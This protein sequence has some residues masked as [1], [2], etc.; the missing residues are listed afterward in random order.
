[1]GFGLGKTVSSTSD[2]GSVGP[3]CQGKEMG[4]DLLEMGDSGPSR[5][6]VVDFKIV[7][8]VAAVSYVLCYN[9]FCYH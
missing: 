1:M 5:F 4:G 6:R 9:F 8:L 7:I 2:G 3:R